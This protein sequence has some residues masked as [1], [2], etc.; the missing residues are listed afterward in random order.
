MQ[1]RAVPPIQTAAAQRIDGARAD[2]AGIGAHEPHTLV[3]LSQ[4][5]TLLE[6]LTRAAA[7]QANVIT[8][9]SADRF[10]DQL[11]ATAAPLALID[12][13]AAPLPLDAFI[14]SLTEQFPKL[15]LVLAGPA[16]LQ[17]QF[18]S[19]IADGSIFRFAHKPASAQRLKLFIDAGVRRLRMSDDLGP[20]SASDIAGHGERQP[21]TRSSAGARA[22]WLSAA[23]LAAIAAAF[24]TFRLVSRDSTPALAA[25]PPTRAAPSPA[26][27]ATAV[28]VAL[29]PAPLADTGPDAAAQAAKAEQD[30]LAA[31]GRARE[32]ALQQQVQRTASGARVDQAHVY[33]Q[34]A[35]KRLASGGLLEPADDSAHTYVDAALALAPDDEDVRATAAALGEALMAQFRKAAAA[36]DIAMAQTWFQACAD[37][38]IN[39]VTLTQFKAQ[40]DALQDAQRA[41][42]EQLHSLQQDFSQRVAQGQLVEPAD[43]SALLKYRKFKEM[44]ADDSALADMQRTLRGAIVTEIQ[45]RIARAQLNG[46]ELLLRTAREAGL[47]G[48]ELTAANSAL[49]AARAAAAVEPISTPARPSNTANDAVPESTL[50]RQHFVQPIYPADAV[51]R[52]ISGSVDLEFT[53]NPSGVVTDIRVLTSEPRGVFEQAAINALA[54]NRYVPV[55]REG[56]AVA[57]RAH[58]KMRFAL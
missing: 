10:I 17:H 31:E 33:V 5:P 56:V 44:S 22:L 32:E 48:D 41:H 36:A 9:P 28:V 54:K 23:A 47:D 58:I 19:Q 49:S 27:A 2:A 16:Q 46:A 57:Q 55:Q 15:L 7:G 25:V 37:F 30:R 29:P 39:A 34:L 40:L 4:D 24:V 35:R 6:S 43:D 18:S 20:F 12:A 45:N 11:F 52:G 13:G 3:A 26:A 51:A 53:V 1:P 42:F 21:K 50:T 8:S 14:I 38:H